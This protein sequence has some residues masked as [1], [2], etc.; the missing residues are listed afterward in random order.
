MYIGVDKCGV[1][2]SACAPQLVNSQRLCWSLAVPSKALM[3]LGKLDMALQDAQQSCALSESLGR[4]TPMTK[5]RVEFS[6]SDRM[7]CGL[8]H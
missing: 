2:Q 4:G 3:Q 6:H 7:L 1:S 8:Y 5:P